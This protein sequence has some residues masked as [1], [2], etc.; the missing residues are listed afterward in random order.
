MPRC[1]IPDAN[2]AGVYSSILVSNIPS[3]LTKLT[4]SLHITHPYDSDLVLELIS[5]DGTT[6]ILSRNNGDLRR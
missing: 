2:A 5:P 3:A 1:V 4:V 6:N